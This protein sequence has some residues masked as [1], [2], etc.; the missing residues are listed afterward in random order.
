MKFSDLFLVLS[1]EPLLYTVSRIATVADHY[2]HCMKWSHISYR[3]REVQGEGPTTKA[4]I[5]LTQLSLFIDTTL[6][7]TTLYKNNN[8]R[9]SSDM[10]NKNTA[11]STKA[12]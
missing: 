7:K 6:I 8:Y 11:T 9:K 2:N 1:H 12:P 4:V 3:L 5:T 10:L